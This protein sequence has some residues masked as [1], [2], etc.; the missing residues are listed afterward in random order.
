MRHIILTC[1]LLCA[2]CIATSGDLEQ[3]GAEITERIAVAARSAEESAS[4]AREAWKRGEI[5]Y[6]ELQSRLQDI[7]SAT[8]D[9]AR[10]TTR[11]VVA[12][13][14]ET[15]EQRPE[16]VAQTGATIAQTALPGPLGE[17]LGGLIL[18][19]GAYAAARSKSREDARHMSM[20]RDLARASRG[21]PV[22]SQ[23]K[24]AS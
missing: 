6:A 7:R 21:E 2:S 22:G 3:M 19:G 15:I 23:K 18:A 24:G 10:E 8:L 20:E 4:A 13:V 12:G 17:L 9:V 14:R 16:V 11:E 5:D 1:T